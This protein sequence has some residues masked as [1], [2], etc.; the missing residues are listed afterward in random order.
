MHVGSLQCP[1][2]VL[3]STMYALCME[4]FSGAW[5]EL[6]PSI[7]GLIL[8]TCVSAAALNILGVIVIKDVGASSMEI[9]GKLNVLVTIALSMVFLGETIPHMVLMGTV[10]VMA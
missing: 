10:I 1:V 4:S 3:V 8:C 7:V 9:V 2:V 5:D 6:T